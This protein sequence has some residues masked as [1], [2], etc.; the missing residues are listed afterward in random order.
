MK[1][2]VLKINIEQKIWILMFNKKFI[3]LYIPEQSNKNY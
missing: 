2:T 3:K 1:E